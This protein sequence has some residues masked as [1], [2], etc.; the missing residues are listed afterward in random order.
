MKFRCDKDEIVKA[1]NHAASIISQKTTH[2]ILQ[3]VL[4]EAQEDKIS[5]SATDLEVGFITSIPATIEQQGDITVLA[6]KLL[7]L[8]K[9]VPPCTLIFELEENNNV[10]IYSEDT[11]IDT[12][13]H[14]HGIPRIDF[15]EIRK[16]VSEKYFEFPQSDL[17]KMIRKT[18]YAVSHEETRYYLNGAFF[19][20]EGKY[21]K[22]VSTDS[23][24]LAYIHKDY[25]L[26]EPDFGLIV[27]KKIL[28]QLTGI[29]DDQGTLN[30]AIGE[31]QIFFEIGDMYFVSNLLDGNFPDYKKVIPDTHE[32]RIKLNNQEFLTT[33]ERVSPM[34]D[35]KQQIIL[36]LK[37]GEI[38]VLARNP[39]HGD[40]KDKIEVDY[41]G[42]EMEIGFNFRYLIDAI[43]EIDQDELVFDIISPNSPTV[44][45]GV[46]IE[47]YIAIIM[48]MKIT[49]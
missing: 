22:M 19:Q 26:D 40:I 12:E 13:I 25:P 46:D 48:P 49:S 14:I 35:F 21:L 8:I 43:K 6:K 37:P 23:R 32:I 36:T 31:K 11:G 10:K 1:I 2:N 15:P 9:R 4:L 45:R 28:N 7:E 30:I 24:R 18:L 5:I 34:S 41:D 38:V 17:K 42:P 29:L 44:L 16:P 39:D 3:N 20:K 33:I 27:P 47:D